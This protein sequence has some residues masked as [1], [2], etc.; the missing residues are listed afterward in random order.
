MRRVESRLPVLTLVRNGESRTRRGN[1]SR[2]WTRSRGGDRTVQAI[3]SS[4]APHLR[5]RFY[6]CLCVGERYGDSCSPIC[7]SR[8]G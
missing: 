1:S 2:L 8:I 6:M 3:D 5:V 7:L 4:P